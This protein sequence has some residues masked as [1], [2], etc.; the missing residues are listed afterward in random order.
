MVERKRVDCESKSHIEIGHFNEQ[1]TFIK[2][3]WIYFWHD[4]MESVKRVIFHNTFVNVFL[5]TS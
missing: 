4:S 3:K 1:H 5:I 2:V